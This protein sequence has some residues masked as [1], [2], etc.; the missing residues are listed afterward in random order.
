M[1]YVVDHHIYVIIQGFCLNKR[2]RKEET[3][4][5]RWCAYGL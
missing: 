3:N 5:W 2:K 1:L 4:Y